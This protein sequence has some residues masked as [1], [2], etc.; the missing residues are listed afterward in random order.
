MRPKKKP[1]NLTIDPDLLA[2]AKAL[3]LNV[4]SILEESLKA[5]VREE[6]GCRWLIEN[7]EA[8][9]AYNRDIRENGVWSERLRRF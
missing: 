9:E 3:G 4:S 7:R 8:I 1:T 5:K 2:K 6:E